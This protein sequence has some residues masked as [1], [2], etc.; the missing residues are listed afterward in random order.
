MRVIREL[1]LEHSRIT[2]FAWNNRYIIK[3]EQGLMEQT[4]KINQSDVADEDTL[5]NMIDTVFMQQVD[6]RFVEMAKSISE[7]KGRVA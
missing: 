6:T 7:A 1:T 3:F 5:L 4:F 2:F